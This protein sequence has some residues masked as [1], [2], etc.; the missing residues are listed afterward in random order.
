MQSLF[1]QSV[2]KDGGVALAI[3]RD[4]IDRFISIFKYWKYGSDM[5]NHN[6]CR[7]VLRFDTQRCD[8]HESRVGRLDS[9][10]ADDTTTTGVE[11][12]EEN[13]SKRLVVRDDLED[14]LRRW[15]R[16]STND[17]Q[18]VSATD[19]TE[20][21]CDTEHDGGNN[22]ATCTSCAIRWL[23]DWWPWYMWEDH[24]LPQT[25]WLNDKGSR[26][27]QVVLVR[28]VADPEEFSARIHRAMMS[29][30]VGIDSDVKKIRVRNK[31]SSGKLTK[32]GTEVDIDSEMCSG[33]TETDLR[34]LHQDGLFSEDFK[35][36]TQA[37]V[38][39]RSGSGPWKAVF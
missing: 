15:K 6:N 14:F 39:A 36:W 21:C 3:I 34:W 9:P 29:V 10:E 22:L 33:L 35:L 26:R 11:Y 25:H 27:S 38:Q 1:E 2:Y 7:E 20:G 17:S 12:Y 37:E 8:I 32:S 30:G 23:P 28:Y 31:S 19:A 24:F 5:Y 16:I 13:G 4:P 18:A